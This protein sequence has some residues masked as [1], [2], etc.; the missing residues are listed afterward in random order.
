MSKSIRTYDELL[1]Y[2]EQLKQDM[3]THRQAIR[4]DIQHLKVE[5]MPL[6][7]AAGAASKLFIRNKDHS[8]FVN[9]A[10]SLIDFALR[11]IVLRK[12]GWLTRLV[13]PFIAKNISSHFVAGKQ[14]DLLNK[15][16]AMVQGSLFPS[17]GKPKA[18][19]SSDGVTSHAKTVSQA[20]GVGD[21]QFGSVHRHD[22]DGKTDYA[23]SAMDGSTTRKENS[24]R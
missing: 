5:F 1:A 17:D 7:N 22:G 13:V 6:T 14:Y 23:G 8:I 10:G 9:G 21:H 3:K 12:S 11:K 20:R 2:Q 24:Y 18:A 15:L 4:E 16:I 19:F